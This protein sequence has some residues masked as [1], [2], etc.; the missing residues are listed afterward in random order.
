VTEPRLARIPGVSLSSLSGPLGPDHTEETH[1][2]Y[3]H[4]IHAGTRG[5]SRAFALLQN[6]ALTR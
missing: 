5:I 6:P 1:V 4:D 3:E 2:R